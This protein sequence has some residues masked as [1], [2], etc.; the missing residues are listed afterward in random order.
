MLIVIL[1]QMVGLEIFAPKL[2][3]L[4]TALI[5]VKMNVAFPKIRRTGLPKNCFRVHI[6]DG[7]PRSIA[8]KELSQKSLKITP[9]LEIGRTD[10]IT[11]ILTNR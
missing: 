8:D 1:H 6:L 5:N 7:K 11:N 2:I 4:E 9:V 3:Y 10:I